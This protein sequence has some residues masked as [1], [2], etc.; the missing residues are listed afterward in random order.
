MFCMLNKWESGNEIRWSEL[1]LSLPKINLVSDIIKW[2]LKHFRRVSTPS[3]QFVGVFIW[4]LNSGFKCRNAPGISFLLKTF[5]VAFHLCETILQMKSNR[6]F[7]TNQI[8]D[9]SSQVCLY[10][11]RFLVDRISLNSNH[12]SPFQTTKWVFLFCF[13]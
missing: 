10:S 3:K 11:I 8:V 4:Y 5:V 13:K 1:Q 6:H 2:M 7:E 12:C 9:S